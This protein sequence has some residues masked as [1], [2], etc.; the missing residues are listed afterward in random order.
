[1]LLQPLPLQRFSESDLRR[2]LCKGP[3]LR[4]VSNK[5]VARAI[6]SRGLR[7]AIQDDAAWLLG[8]AITW[9]DTTGT[10]AITLNG[11]TSGSI[12]QGVKSGTL[13]T[14]PTGLSTAVLPDEF[15]ITFTVQY[16]AAPAAGGEVGL[17]FSFSSSAT[18]GTANPGNLSGTDAT[19]PNVDVL[20]MLS[21]AGAQVASNNLSSST[22]QP[23]KLTCRVLDNYASP[24]VYNNSS[25][26]LK[27]SNDVTIISAVPRWRVRST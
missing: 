16:N 12:R 22:N 13:V 7:W 11:L 6:R 25:V 17:Y 9:S 23:T 15:S 4:D 2:L 1:M 27:A 21:F 5:E 10:Y 20:P 19:G 26:T 3:R 18:A 8:S 24:V 14:A